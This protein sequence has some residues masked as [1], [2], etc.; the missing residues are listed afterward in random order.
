MPGAT[1][2][3]DPWRRVWRSTLMEWTRPIRVFELPSAR[4]SAPSPASTKAWSSMPRTVSK[5]HS[6]RARDAAADTAV[7]AARADRAISRPIFWASN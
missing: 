1:M 4:I 7:S 3:P 5:A 6:T 2:T